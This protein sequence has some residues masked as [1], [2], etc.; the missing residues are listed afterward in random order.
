MRAAL[1]LLLLGC[2]DPKAIPSQPQRFCSVDAECGSGRYCTE[3]SICR[4]DCTIDAHCYGPTT[5]AQCNSQGKCIDTVDAAAPPEPDAPE[6]DAKPEAAPPE[7][8]G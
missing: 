6:P 8:G 2:S 1:L 5:T 7:A 3:A 4:R